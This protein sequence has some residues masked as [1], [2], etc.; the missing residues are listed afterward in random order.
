MAQ[1][2]ESVS[3]SHDV[4]SKLGDSFESFGIFGWEE[5][6]TGLRDAS[7]A[8]KKLRCPSMLNLRLRVGASS[9]ASRLWLQLG[10]VEGGVSTSCRIRCL[11]RGRRGA[12]K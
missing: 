5:N 10:L 12:V 11:W 7:I 9:G 3:E 1:T 8:M 4:E 2:V 6:K